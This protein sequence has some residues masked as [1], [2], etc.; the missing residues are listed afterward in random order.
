[1]LTVSRTKKHY[2]IVTVFVSILVLAS[3]TTP[4]VTPETALQSYLQTPETGLQLEN[5]QIRYAGRNN[6]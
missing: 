4:K 2:I 5:N 6:S 3:C 1:M